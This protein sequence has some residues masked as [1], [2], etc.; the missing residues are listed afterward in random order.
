MNGG[1]GK[2]ERGLA[3]RVTKWTEKKGFSLCTFPGRHAS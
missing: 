1:H 2:R 3:D